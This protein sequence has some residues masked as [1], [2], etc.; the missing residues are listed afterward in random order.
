M[1]PQEPHQWPVTTEWKRE[2]KAKLKTRGRG[3][4][5]W[6]C[7]EIGISTGTLS[8]MLG[9][10][11]RRSEHV[12]KISKLLDVEWSAPVASRDVPE[13]RHVLRHL[14]PRQQR[15][16]VEFVAVAGDMAGEMTDEQFSEM[17]ESFRTLLKLSGAAR[18]SK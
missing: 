8:E 1:A 7:R 13:I 9:P 5:S 18:K 14:T 16:F 17:F 11:G 2:V 12:P 10:E 3:A 4:Q 15:Q 6:L